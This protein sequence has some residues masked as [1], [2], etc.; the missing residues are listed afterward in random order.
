MTGTPRPPVSAEFPTRLLEGYNTFRE[1]RLPRERARFEE[2]AENGQKPEIMVIACCDSR[3]SPE[4]IFDARPGELFVVRNV[5]NLVPPYT[6]DG[7]LHGTSAALEFA[8]QALRVRHIVVMGHGRCGGVH[9]YVRRLRNPTAEDALSPGDFIGRWMT[10]I[11]PAAESL[12]AQDEEGDREYAER[13]AVA[14]IRN[15]IENMLT[16]PCVNILHGRGQL[17]LHGAM[18]DVQTGLLRTL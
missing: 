7:E 4:V 1:G 8:V 3:V 6:P 17:A 9:S 13:L 14:S 12:P 15:S 10:L 11:S 5:A 2:M 18:F 16:F